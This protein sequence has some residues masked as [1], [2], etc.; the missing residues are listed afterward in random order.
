MTKK[1]K[2]LKV[3][4]F[5]PNLSG[6]GAERAVLSLSKAIDKNKF[7]MHVVV[8]EKT[9]SLLKSLDG[10]INISFIHDG[11]Y[12]RTILPKLF[13]VTLIKSFKAD[14]L[15]GANEG[16][17]TFFALIAG[18]LFRKPVISWIHNN[19]SSFSK[20]VSWRQVVSIK[21]ATKL[22]SKLVACSEGVSFDLISNFGV[23]EN[24]LQT[25]YHGF[26]IEKIRE[27]GDQPLS[28]EDLEV[29]SKICGGNSWTA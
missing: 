19:W 10:T 22:S 17:A 2:R 9:G 14:V 29:F 26:E 16:R 1:N 4:A 28:K 13:L 7:E 8:H 12:R 5:I 21:A 27:Q 3:V 25:I 23:P 20:V 6:G 24:K 15:I 18:V 11:R